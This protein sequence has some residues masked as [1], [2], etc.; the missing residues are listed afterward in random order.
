MPIESAAASTSRKPSS[1]TFESSNDSYS[2]VEKH[3]W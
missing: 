3:G 1:E 2:F